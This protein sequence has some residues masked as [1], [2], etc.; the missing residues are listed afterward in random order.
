MRKLISAFTAVIA[1]ITILYSNV[2]TAPAGVINAQNYFDYSDGS[3]YYVYK[4]I[5]KCV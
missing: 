4:N 1:A 2:L 5:I 3:R